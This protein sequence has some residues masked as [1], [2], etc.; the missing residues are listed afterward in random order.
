MKKNIL[1]ENMRRFK[2][3]NLNEGQ[4][5]VT[6]TSN[7]TRGMDTAE[8]ELFDGLIS[9]KDLEDLKKQL[10]TKFSDDMFHM[11]DVIV[12]PGLDGYDYMI[13]LGDEI[14][15]DVEKIG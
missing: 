1:A 6:V 11:Q 5:R 3:K 4:Y 2:T 15:A 12:E 10:V 8:D 14:V 13:A 7:I 9:A